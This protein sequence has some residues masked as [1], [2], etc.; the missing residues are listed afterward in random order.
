[1]MLNN[2]LS[3]ITIT[4]KCLSYWFTNLNNEEVN[5]TFK[6][7]LLHIPT[8][9]FLP[10]VYQ[11]AARMALTNDKS[12]S[13]FHSILLEYLSRCIID[14]PHHVLP[15]IFA[16]VNAHKDAHINQQQ[17][18]SSTNTKK[19]SI[20]LIQLNDEINNDPRSRAAQY[21]LDECAKVKPN[22][23]DQMRK[24]NDAY[25]EAAYWDVPSTKTEQQGK[26]PN[27]KNPIFSKHLRLMHIKDFHEVVVSTITIPVTN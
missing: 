26:D 27:A 24:L 18:T 10:F 3:E 25:I 13:S 6:K 2:S 8:Y 20:G 4:S 22:L 17:T 21:L 14:H 23:V 5:K 19:N 16:L 12:S 9:F 15:V 11:M 1:M 7:Y